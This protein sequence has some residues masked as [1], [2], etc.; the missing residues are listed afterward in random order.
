[1]WNIHNAFI[2][3]SV[4]INEIQLLPQDACSEGAGS[5]SKALASEL[6]T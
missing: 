6:S 5:D 1:M 3:C 4:I 2:I